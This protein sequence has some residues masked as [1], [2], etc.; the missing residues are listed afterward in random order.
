MS[1]ADTLPPQGIPSTM[2]IDERGRV[3]AR[4]VGT[5]TEVTLVDMIN[6]VANGR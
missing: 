1:L 4:V 2:T 5:V 3:A 6:D